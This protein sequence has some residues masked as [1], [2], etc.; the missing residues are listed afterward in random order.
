MNDWL[1]CMLNWNLIA[2]L[3][4]CEFVRS[5]SNSAAKKKTT[6]TDLKCNISMVIWR[7]K[8]FVVLDSGAFAIKR[9]E[10]I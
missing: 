4:V 7:G 5:E 2:D 10:L 6:T 1:I 3:N 8:Q 9:I